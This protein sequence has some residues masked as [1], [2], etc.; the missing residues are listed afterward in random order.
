LLPDEYHNCVLILSRLD[1]ELAT[2]SLEAEVLV[3]MG[4]DLESQEYRLK[5]FVSVWK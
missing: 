1:P 4:I 5:R 3:S 2:D